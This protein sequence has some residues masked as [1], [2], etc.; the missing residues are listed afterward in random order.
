MKLNLHFLLVIIMAAFSTSSFAALP[1]GAPA[2]NFTITDINGNVHTLY[3]YLDQ[4]KPVILNLSATWCGPCWNY[5]NTQT[6]KNFY[7]QYGPPGTN[8]VMVFH[9]EADLGTNLDCLYGLPT[10]QGGTMGNWVDNSPYPIFNLTQ[11]NGAHIRGDYAL[12][13]Y[14]TIYAISP[15]R[16]AWEI[17]QAQ[18]WKL[19]SWIF[20]SFTLQASVSTTDSYCGNNGTATASAQGG[21]SGVN[22]LW[23]TGMSG[24]SVSNLPAGTFNVTATDNNGYFVVE[25]YTLSGSL[26]GQQ[27]SVQQQDL[28]NVL[29]NGEATG[30]VGALGSGGNFGYQYQWSNGVN[31][32]HIYNVGA[33]FY[34]VT[35]TDSQNCATTATYEISQP[36]PLVGV[37]YT[38]DATCD[39]FNGQVEFFGLGGVGPYEF[40]FGNGFVPNT[41]YGN[42]APGTYNFITR[43]NNL[44]EFQSSFTIFTVGV[45]TAQAAANQA[46]DCEIT[47]VMVSGVGSSTGG[48]ISYA[49]STNDGNIVSGQNQL[50]CVVNQTGTYTLTVTNNQ[51]NCQRTASATV[52]AVVEAPVVNVEDHTDLNCA[53]VTTILSAAGSSF[54]EDF[55]ISWTTENGTIISGGDELE[56][57]VGSAGVYNLTI[58]NLLNGC[59]SS[60]DVIVVLD[61]VSPVGETS[62][63]LLTCQDTQVELCVTTDSDN[64]VVWFIDNEEQEGACALVNRAGVF[65]AVVIGANG[66]TTAVE[67]TVVADENIPSVEV[68]ATNDL[69]CIVR[70]ANINA[71]IVQ[72]GDFTYE[73]TTENGV[74]ISG[75]D[76]ETIT[77]GAEGTYQLVVTNNENGCF[78]VRSIT[79]DDFAVEPAAD[80]S[81]TMTRGVLTLYN[82]SN[83]ASGTVVW[84]I[85]DL[86][87]EG[88][89]VEV[90]LGIT[91]TYTICLTVENECGSDQ[92]CEELLYISELKALGSV[93]H[94]SC[95]GSNDGALSIAPEGG[96]PGY[97]I[98]WVGMP[99]FTGEF[100]LENLSP[101]VYTY[102]IVDMAGNEQQETIEI[103]EPAKISISADAS[104]VSCYGG[105]DGQITLELNGGTGDLNIDW[106]EIENNQSEN[107][108]AGV[109]TLVVTDANNCEET[110]VFEIS[111]PAEIVLSDVAVIEATDNQ[112]NGSIAIEVAGGTGAYNAV[113]SNGMTGLILQ[114]VEAGEYFVSVTDEM[115]CV[116]VFGPIEVKSVTNVNDLGQ[117][118]S[119]SLYPNPTVDVINLKVDLRNTN[120]LNILLRDNSGKLV[121]Q[122]NISG[123]N[124]TEVINVSDLNPGIYMLELQTETS[125]RVEKFIVIK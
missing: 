57:E 90:N 98:E 102:I 118:A 51:Y 32:S 80:F 25:S 106:L 56:V 113:W 39:N 17:G 100:Q 41:Y 2:P 77:V 34:T 104:N 74:I 85:G 31:G 76:G 115:G 3:D 52:Q 73:W 46:L 55:E 16:R 119:I 54:G 125:V 29:C 68:A 87:I 88:N 99:E 92:I 69:D 108:A 21:Y 49:W 6:L 70:T 33:G 103:F 7:N 109:Y 122:R 62:D 8:E 40:N 65:N 12:S 63:Q 43:D 18:P 121:S 47:Q 91:G 50:N 4:G 75:A 117:F 78:A 22:F 79:I 61:D 19:Q 82:N 83:L 26:S 66:C 124:I 15:D 14:P 11:A 93:L 5:H 114:G 95:F 67:A 110:M 37:G 28:S 105:N 94:V 42:L 84:T 13:Y 9:V 36:T 1:P 86:D 58:T 97:D 123:N 89:Q 27:L 112:A 20:E 24:P 48:N 116:K 107:L 71:D 23:H 44:C 30:S 10:C 111:Q 38:I 101:G 64:T 72:E 35:V 59:S 53:N 45:P 60:V 96:L 120:S 81:Y